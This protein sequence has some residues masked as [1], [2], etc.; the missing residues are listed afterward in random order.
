MSK[1]LSK[2]RK[3]HDRCPLPTHTRTIDQETTV[4][5]D[6]DLTRL[7]TKKKRVMVF[8]AKEQKTK[9]IMIFGM[10]LKTKS[11]SPKSVINACI[12]QFVVCG[13]RL[14]RAKKLVASLIEKHNPKDYNEFKKYIK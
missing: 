3:Q 4:L 2:Y 7:K 10:P 12:R 6:I 11:Q 8:M 14:S 5:I 13:C 1:L 9:K